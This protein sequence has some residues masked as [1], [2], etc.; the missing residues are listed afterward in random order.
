MTML[1]LLLSLL[2]RLLVLLL[3]HQMMTAIM[4]MT[5][6]SMIS[7]NVQGQYDHGISGN[8]DNI[9]GNNHVS[10][11]DEDQVYKDNRH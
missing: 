6:T 7:E 10:D 5:T 4:T 11:D 2:L 8:A 3:L 1:P 9:E